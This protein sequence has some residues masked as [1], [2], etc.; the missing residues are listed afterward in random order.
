MAAPQSLFV[1]FAG[2]SG[3]CPPMRE[4][5]LLTVP[6]LSVKT[7]GK[8]NAFEKTSPLPRKPDSFSA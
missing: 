5:E 4:R 1:L 2:K 6:G 8:S 3:L 7:A